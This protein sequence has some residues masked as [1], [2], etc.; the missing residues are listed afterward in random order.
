MGEMSMSAEPEEKGIDGELYWA[1]C[2]FIAPDIDI[3]IPLSLCHGLT[4][5]GN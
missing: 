5:S 2:L 1:Y 3:D 4:P